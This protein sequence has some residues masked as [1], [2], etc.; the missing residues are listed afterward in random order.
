MSEDFP[1][2]PA[3]IADRYRVIRVIGKG[4]MGV[5][6]EA[7]QI[8]LERTVAIKLLKSPAQARSSKRF[9]LEA[10]TLAR[11]SHPNTVRI[12]ESGRDSGTGLLYL[13]MEFVN[14]KTLKALVLERGQLAPELAI[15]LTLQICSALAEAHRNG[16]IHR[17]IKPVNILV[18]ETP[19]L[20]IKLLDFGLVKLLNADHEISKT[21]A[22]LGSPMYMT[23][24]QIQASE[25][26]ERTDVYSLGLTLMFMLTGQNPYDPCELGKLLQ[27]Q[28]SDSPRSLTL[29]QPNLS[30]HPQL[31][32]CV[33]TAVRKAPEQRFQ[34]MDSFQQALKALTFKH[35]EESE[36]PATEQI[37][38]TRKHNSLLGTSLMISVL[39]VLVSIWLGVRHI[40][41]PAPALLLESTPN[42]SVFQSGKV[43]GTTPLKLQL[44]PKE[45][46]TVQLQ[47]P[48]YESQEVTLSPADSKRHIELRPLE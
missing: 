42:A 23:P 30:Q 12:F 45:Q 7:E 41:R 28:L 14:G 33:A 29:L 16:I 26:D 24:E 4:G 25:I 5:V 19:D 9:L 36:L 2:I 31:I 21:G 34:N 6:V 39:A 37:E 32:N 18:T 46:L 22:I 47:Q 27:K 35:G 43:I 15:Y 17:D 1:Q 13:V 44:Q 20:H 40:Q 38:S 3:L 48:G 8:G 11:L 10:R